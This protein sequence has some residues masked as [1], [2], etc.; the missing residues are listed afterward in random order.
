MGD[1]ALPAL[2]ALP[3][4][5]HPHAL[6]A[7]RRFRWRAPTCAI[8]CVWPGGSSSVLILFMARA[9]E[10]AYI[11]RTW[12]GRTGRKGWRSGEARHKTRLETAEQ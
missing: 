4:T 9:T 10:K 8:K 7:T 2:P 1:S 3:P 5:A 12:D 11:S 6:P